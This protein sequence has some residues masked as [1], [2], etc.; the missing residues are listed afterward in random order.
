MK[1]VQLRNFA[2]PVQAVAISPDYK[3]DRTYVSGGLAGNLVVTVG[4]K[5]GTRS[6]STTTGSTSATATG[7]LNTIGLAG[8]T[9]K[10]NVL[11]YGEGTITTIKWSLSGKYVV[12]INEHGIR[13]MRSNLHLE[14]IDSDSAWKR[15]GHVSRPQDG[16]W[17]DMASV[18]KGR[19]EWIDEKKLE[20][21][22]DGVAL[23]KASQSLATT[24]LI[25]QSSK[26][27][28][29]IE[30]LLVGWGDAMWIINVY[31]EGTG[32]GRHVGERTAGRAEVIKL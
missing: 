6:T 25:K 32:V 27:K 28:E 8:N 2:R 19:A 9:G 5:A 16:Q 26:G 4:G 14:S 11:H 12:W 30:K 22:E 21:D 15:I 13:I 31:P 24:K 29:K 7:W 18:W 17:D 10:D 23:E 3:N 20:S 1:D